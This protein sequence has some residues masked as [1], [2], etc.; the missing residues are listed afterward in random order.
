MLSGQNQKN[1]ITLEQYIKENKMIGYKEFI[2]EASTIKINIE[3]I[4]DKFSD[5]GEQEQD[6]FFYFIDSL[7]QYGLKDKDWS[8]ADDSIIEIP[9]KFKKFTKSWNVELVTEAKQSTRILIMLDKLVVRNKLTNKDSK[10]AYKVLAK[11]FGD[12]IADAEAEDVLEILKD[13][14]LINE[15]AIAE[16]E[17]WSDDGKIRYFDNMELITAIVTLSTEGKLRNV[18]SKD[19]KEWA[20]VLRLQKEI[21]G[22]NQSEM[23]D[24]FSGFVANNW[25]PKMKKWGLI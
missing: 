8:Y 10:K 9:A 5:G 17:S 13:E 16:S 23:W 4:Q 20:K 12:N 11:I 15:V 7:K 18:K 22:M 19:F 24:V 21:R 6:D 25:K 1:L 2:H 3:D 14:G